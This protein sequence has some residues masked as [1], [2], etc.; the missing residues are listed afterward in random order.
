MRGSALWWVVDV[1]QS[2]HRAGVQ[3]VMLFKGKSG[4]HLT[5]FLVRWKNYIGAV[6]VDG[7][8]GRGVVKLCETLGEE[9][10]V[11]GWMLEAGGLRG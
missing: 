3:C 4:V 9:S 5:P 10:S 11:D 7:E 8:G 1:D 2:H 6:G